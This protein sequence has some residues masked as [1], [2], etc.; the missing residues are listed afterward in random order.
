M[1]LKPWRMSCNLR[2]H[3][4]L[5]NLIIRLV[6]ETGAGISLAYIAK[7][8]VHSARGALR[9]API[10]ARGRACL[11]GAGVAPPP[12][13]GRLFPRGYWR[14]FNARSGMCVELSMMGGLAC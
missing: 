6:A 1:L 10:T 9:P 8:G 14:C 11:P 12:A 4:N 5:T 13:R 3:T 2:L 7:V